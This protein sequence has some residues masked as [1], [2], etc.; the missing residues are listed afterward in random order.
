MIWLNT[1]R[2]PPPAKITPKLDHYAG[3]VIVFSPGVL[4]I[5]ATRF[6]S[7]S[8]SNNFLYNS[9]RPFIKFI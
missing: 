2:S 8:S 6:F 7:D 5:S 9:L 4:Y 1:I 3:C